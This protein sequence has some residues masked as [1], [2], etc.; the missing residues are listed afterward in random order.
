MEGAQKGDK[1]NNNCAQ[2]AKDKND[3]YI[4]HFLEYD[5]GK[6]ISEKDKPSNTY[7]DKN[8][9]T[10]KYCYERC[11][12]CD[13][14]GDKSNN[15]CTE[16][17]KDANNNYLYHFLYNENGKCINETEKPLNTYL[18]IENNTYRL[19][20]ERCSL[21]D[22]GGNK[23]NN[24]CQECLKDANNNYLYHF[25]YNETGRC[26]NE[27]EKPS[28][29]YLNNEN[30]TYLLCH[31]S[32]SLCESYQECKE[33]LKDESNNYI[34]HFIDEKKGKCI[35]MSELKEGYYYLDANDNTYKKCPEGTFKV[36]DDKCIEYNN[37]NI[38]LIFIIIISILILIP[39]FLIVLMCL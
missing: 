33:C 21:C 37:E 2:C 34:Y 20:Y 10:Y 32:C 13:K 18:D 27:F 6:C 15:N 25:L 8:D 17:L 29:T 35:N 7:L 31:G 12:L 16:C 11:S 22:K 1:D 3:N 39:S 14:G 30:N 24:N 4:Y 38:L 9:N 28:N 26:L 5:K 23:N 19:C 36:E